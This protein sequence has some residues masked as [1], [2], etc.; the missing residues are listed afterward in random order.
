[1]RL[2]ELHR[3][4]VTYVWFS[5]TRGSKLH[6]VPVR[7]SLVEYKGPCLSNPTLRVADLQRPGRL[8]RWTHPASTNTLLDNFKHKHSALNFITSH[9]RQRFIFPLSQTFRL[10]QC[11]DLYGRSA[12]LSHYITTTLIHYNT[13]L[14][15]FGFLQWCMSDK[16]VWQKLT[17]LHFEYKWQSSLPN[18]SVTAALTRQLLFS[19]PGK[20]NISELEEG[21]FSHLVGGVGVGWGVYCLKKNGF[22]DELSAH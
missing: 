8:K 21:N 7:A 20:Q 16:V 12:G 17:A 4:G 19:E 11:T 14:I 3:S 6:R 13:I 18:V 1:M 9:E 2:F 15:S 10:M 5:L 22:E